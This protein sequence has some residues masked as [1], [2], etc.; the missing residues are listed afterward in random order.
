MHLEQAETINTQ[1][2]KDRASV[3]NFIQAK[4]AGY[5]AAIPSKPKPILQQEDQQ[6]QERY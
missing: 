2:E 6:A 5:E 3:S 1:K 4:R